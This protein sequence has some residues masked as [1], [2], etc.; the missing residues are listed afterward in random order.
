MLVRQ[1][2]KILPVLVG[3]DDDFMSAHAV[4][5]VIHAFALAIERSFN[6]EGRKFVRNYAHP[7]SGWVLLAAGV[8][9]RQEFP[10]RL[11]LIAR[12]KRAKFAHA[13]FHLL[14]KIGGSLAPVCRD[15]HPTAYHRVASQLSHCRYSL[16]LA[17]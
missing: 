5:L 13:G 9:I 2:R 14:T 8:V 11:I 7:P 6:L 17:F 3:L 1:I 4:H 12:A 10:G 16:T 15:N